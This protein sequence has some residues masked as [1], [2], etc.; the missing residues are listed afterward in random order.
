MTDNL[1]YAESERLKNDAI[2]RATKRWLM[3]RGYF[4]SSDG[5]YFYIHAMTYGDSS[6]RL[7]WKFKERHEAY[8]KALEL[9]AK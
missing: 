7:S 5:D 4:I 3:E 1:T 6:D 9:A 2:A 8:F